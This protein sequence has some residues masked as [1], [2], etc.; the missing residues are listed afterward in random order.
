[1]KTFSIMET[2]HNLARVLRQ[3]EAGHEVGITRRKKLVA[4]IL[5]PTNPERVEF[6]DFAERAKRVWGKS[7]KGTSSSELLNESRGTQ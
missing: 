4:R 6:P 2:Q 1:M 3:V 7:W 5:P